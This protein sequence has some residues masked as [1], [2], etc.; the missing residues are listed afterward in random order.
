MII[1]MI[2]QY[3]GILLLEILFIAVIILASASWYLGK[4]LA[5]VILDGKRN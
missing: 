4:A 3:L 1:E 2:Y 5:E